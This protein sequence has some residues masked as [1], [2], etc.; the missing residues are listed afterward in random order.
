MSTVSGRLQYDGARTATSATSN[1]G[2]QGVAI[3]LQD[4]GAQGSGQGLAVVTLTNGNGTFEFSG[5]PAGN[6]QLVEAYGTPTTYTAA[7]DWSTATMRPI[8]N[9]GTTPPI[10]YASP[11]AP[12]SATHLDCTMRNTR[13]LTIDGVTNLTGQDFLNGPVRITPLALAP[14]VMVDPPNLITA[15]DNGTF[16]SFEPGMVA[17]TGVEVTAPQTHPYP[18]IQSQFHYTMP[19]LTPS[20]VTPPDGYYT[21]QNI[22]NNTW[23]NTHPT[24]ANP[25]WWRVADHTTGNEMGRM[26]VI[27]GYTAGTVIGQTTVAV[28]PNTNYLT[29]YWILNLCRQATGY[30]NPE[31]SLLITDQDGTTIFTHDFSDEILPN[32]QCPE[33]KQIGVTFKTADDTTA[34]T[35]EFISQGGPQTGNDYALDDVALNRVDIVEL[36]ITKEVS[37]TYATQGGTLYYQISISNPTDCVATQ[38]TLTDDLDDQFDDLEFT[39]DGENWL[40]WTGTLEIDDIAPNESGNVII[41]GKVKQTAAGTITN[42]ASVQVTFCQTEEDT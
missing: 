35:I 8:I 1:P 18:E 4:L 25:A 5:V 30:I 42:S 38:I 15:A 24:T 27:N 22:M 41:R 12:S 9:G 32:T 28:D 3:V 10:S 17:N 2:L 39:L 29:S 14:N 21:V 23:S 11:N 33:W 6:Y 26:M 13:L 40:L 7:T 34:I 31:F 16:G 37:C 20:K 36:D 19:E